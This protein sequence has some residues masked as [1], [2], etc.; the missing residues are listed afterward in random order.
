M[1][2]TAYTLSEKTALPFED[3]V[4]RVREEL[5]KEGFGVLC[6]IDV[7]ATLEEKLDVEREAVHDS[8]RLQSPAG[9][10]GARAGAGAGHAAAMQRRRVS[11]RRRDA[12]RSDRRRADA[13]HRRQRRARPGGDRGE[14]ATWRTSFAEQ[15]S[16]QE[17]R[18]VCSSHRQRACAAEGVP[19]P[20]FGRARRRPPGG[21][22]SR[23]QADDR[24]HAAAR[25]SRHRPHDV[26]PRGLPRRCGCV[27]PR[28]HLHGTCCPRG[29]RLLGA[30][31]RR[32]RRRRH[33]IGRTLR[34]HAA[35]VAAGGRDRSGLGCPPA[36]RAGRG[37]VPRL[38][39]A[40]PARRDRDRR[41]RASP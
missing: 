6:E 30:D 15:R 32:R 39:L 5:K 7:Q 9:A 4:E 36:R 3:A 14:R 16:R 33:A 28:R 38:R 41:H 25:V 37:E 10:P 24:D 21:G 27:V 2:G 18:D 40:R 34:L 1:L 35:A 17:V 29:A 13:V 11:R 22:A 31:G 23:R 26:E 19:L 20:A 8:R 12:H